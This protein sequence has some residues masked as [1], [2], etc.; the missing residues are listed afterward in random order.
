MATTGNP[1][2]IYTLDDL[3][4]EVVAVT[5]ARTSR[6]PE[7]FDEIARELTEESSSR[8]HE[9][10]VVGYGHSSVA[11][12]AVLSIA[13]ENV[14]ILGAKIIEDNRLSSFTEK[15]TRYQVMSSDNYYTPSVFSEDAA[16]EIYRAAVRDLYDTYEALLP[17]ARR[18]A[19]EKYGCPSW[20]ERGV[21]PGGKACDT[22]RGLLPAAA[23]TNLGWTVNA[24]SLRHAVVKLGSHPLEEMRDLAEGL[25]RVAGERV[26]TLLRYTEPSPY[27]SGWEERVG[28]LVPDGG[29]RTSTENGD[30]SSVRLVEHDPAGERAVLRAILFRAGG[31]S[32]DD[33]RRGVDGWSRERVSAALEE[34]LR[35]VGDHEAPVRELEATTYTFEIT[36]D[37]GAYRD[38]QRHRMATQTRQPLTAE[39]GYVIPDDAR[40]AGVAA[41]MTEGLERVRD[42]WR[43]LREVDGTAAQYVVP[44][45]YRVRFLMSMNLREAYIFCRLRSRVQG[46]ESYR[47]IA[48]AVRDEIER[49]HPM[50]GRL[51]P[52]DR[53]TAGSALVEKEVER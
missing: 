8:F 21:T 39:L 43:A 14:S 17:D 47:R 45:A 38:V 44:L 35:G 49:V 11:E 13:V 29:A 4:P 42:A 50:L 36:C 22:V 46:H 28:E 2:R 18:F 30:G 34:A 10:W 15:S 40:E 5:F 6:S 32:Y 53:Q 41:P 9:K 27:L 24:R 3:P 31:S 12:H 20:R 48:W 37:F 52:V 33:L 7:S 16:G 23:K 51:I 26:P 1:L 19:E 25:T